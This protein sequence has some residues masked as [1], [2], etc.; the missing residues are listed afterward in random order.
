MSDGINWNVMLPVVGACSGTG[1]LR[2]HRDRDLLARHGSRVA[3][4]AAAKA[5]PGTRTLDGR[6]GGSAPQRFQTRLPH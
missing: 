4:R 1:G 3:S 5:A 6:R 2:M